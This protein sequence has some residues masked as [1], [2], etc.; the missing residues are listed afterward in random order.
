MNRVGRI[1]QRRASV[2]HPEFAVCRSIEDFRIIGENRVLDAHQR[3]DALDLAK[4]PDGIAIEPTN[5]V[6]RPVLLALQLRRCSGLTV[7]KCSRMPLSA[8]S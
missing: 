4:V 1:F 8:L 5:D 3:Q 7:P 6:D 2:I